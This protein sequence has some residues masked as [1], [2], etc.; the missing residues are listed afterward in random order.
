MIRPV[1]LY[2]G[3]RYTRAKRRNNFISFISFASM[4][5]IALG[6]AVLVVVLSVMNGFDYQIRHQ[7]FSIAP[8]VTVMTNSNSIVDSWKDVSKQVMTV[9]GV[10]QAAPYLS[11]KGMLTS[12][13][14]VNGV[15]VQGV[16]AS[17]EMKISILPSKVDMGSFDSLTQGSFN[18]VIGGKLAG[19]LGLV[20]GD[21]VT[22]FL[23]ES[24][25]TPFGIIP[26]F[27]RFTVSG[28]FNTGSG[29]GYDTGIAYVNFHD[30]AKLF[31]TSQA[32]GGLHL[33]INNIYAAPGITDTL[34]AMLPPSYY[35]S[36]WTS[37]FGAFFHALAM[38]KTMMFVILLLIVGVAAFNLVATLVMV[39]ND[40]RADIAILRT[41]GASPRTIMM[42][43]VIQ[44]AVV[45]L[46]GTLFGLV[47]GVVLALNATAIVDGIQHLFGVQFI[48]SSVYFI[49]Y[50]P[51]RLQWHDVMTVSSAAFVLSLL[52]TIYPAW[53]AS[54]TQ[55]AEALR[56]E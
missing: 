17:E 24:T 27:K 32:V 44:G 26:R 52:A 47:G 28:V 6:V 22:L 46:I 38:E 12:Q 39:V 45:G 21:K 25:S 29:F 36:N 55:P 51:S 13:G 1:A 40:K 7:F 8:E 10:T 37:Q 31:K 2:I 18:M 48:S 33:K 34:Q 41:L 53:I 11:G 43:F 35:V 16:I 3:L 50:L 30:A 54:R 19:S 14:L 56:Y 23:P 20:V 42:I 15:E 4:I 5:G 49:N 9:P